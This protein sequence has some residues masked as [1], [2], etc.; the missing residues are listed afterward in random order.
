[1]HE[2]DSMD[3]ALHHLRAELFRPS[4]RAERIR[5]WATTKAVKSVQD[6]RWMANV[7]VMTR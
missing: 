1:M 2:Y 4:D 7:E 3:T 6:V 5:Y